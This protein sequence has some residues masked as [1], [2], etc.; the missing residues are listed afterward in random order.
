MSS[1]WLIKHPTMCQII[2]KL[3][4]EGHSKDQDRNR[5]SLTG[6]QCSR[7]DQHSEIG[8]NMTKV[9]LEELGA[10]RSHYRGS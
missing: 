1:A 2:T 3:S 4:T 8:I 5:T 7:E 10:M 9:S 6:L